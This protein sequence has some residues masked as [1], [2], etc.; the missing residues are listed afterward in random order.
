MTNGPDNPLGLAGFEFLE[1]AVYTPKE[2]GALVRLFEGLGLAAAARHRSKD[3]TLYRRGEVNFVLNLEPD[4]FAHSFAL[5]HGPSVCAMAFRVRDAQAALARALAHGEQRYEGR[6]GPGEL[7]IPAIRGLNG[8]LVYLVDL[9]GAKGSIYD[10]DFRMV[11]MPAATKPGPDA[12]DHVSHVVVRGQMEHWVRFYCDIFGFR[13]EPAHRIADASGA[14]LSKV[15]DSPCGLIRI[16]I[17][18]PLDHDTEADHFIHDYFGEG[19]QHIALRTSD[20]MAAVADA[21]RNGVEFL[22]IPETYYAALR[23]AAV[24]PLDLVDRLQQHNILIDIDGGGS[25]LQAYTKPVAGT[26]FFELLERRAHA[27]FGHRNAST[28]LAAL[29]ALRPV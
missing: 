28:R 18:E 9:F 8:S 11:P 6:H 16:P 1:F 4:C 22:P 10:V 20:L 25:L 14:I 5:V 12:I 3:V 15:V 19:V 24:V 29:R 7:D 21:A 17:N 23:A 13:E 26:I 27:G 2:A